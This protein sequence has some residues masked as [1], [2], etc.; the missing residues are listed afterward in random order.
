MPH[1]GRLRS[2]ADAATIETAF[3]PRA[4]AFGF[5]RLVLAA[6]VVYSHSFALGGFGE[7]PLVHFTHGRANLGAV[8]VMGFF[9]VSGFLI[10]RSMASVKSVVTF[11][12]NRF[13]RIFPG[14]WVCHLLVVL[15]LVPLVC[16][17]EHRAIGDFLTA[18]GGAWGTYAKDNALL[19]VHVYD[20][21]PLLAGNPH[22]GSFNGSLWSLI[23]EW[24]CYL[25]VMALGVIAWSSL[26]RWVYLAFA[27]AL[28][29][30]SVATARG[31]VTPQLLPDLLWSEWLLKLGP[32]FFL[33]GVLYLF[34]SRIPSHPALLVAALVLARWGL[35]SDLMPVLG[36]PAIAY[37]AIWLALNLPK[38]LAWFDRAGDISYGVYIYA[39]PAQQL[40]AA[41]GV[42]RIHPALYV[43]ASF[44]LTA[45]LAIAS[46]R[47]V[48]RPSL[49]LKRLDPSLGLEDRLHAYLA[50]RI[51][52]ALPR[53]L[54]APALARVG[55]RR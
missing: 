48:E 40:L 20:I 38:R 43:A 1:S 24:H 36:P 42:H 18:H 21:P 3:D 51:A 52:P 6:L 39:F 53:W 8:S 16:V 35:R 9:A 50:A 22:A 25:I 31:I 13:L 30:A 54:L 37:A 46:F 47:W 15:V 4:N 32:Y 12:W 10:T 49:R 23:I 33:S 5:L 19:R 45:P 11:I 55:Q 41:L 27:L 14:Y 34:R 7:E 28:W 44:A 17:I 2:L 26:F 29:A